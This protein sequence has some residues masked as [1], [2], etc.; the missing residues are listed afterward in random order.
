MKTKNINRFEN[1]TGNK[2]GEE[3]CVT[4]K[5]VCGADFLASFLIPNLWK[6]EHVCKNKF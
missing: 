5:L 2:T 4:V 3:P 6:A 1:K